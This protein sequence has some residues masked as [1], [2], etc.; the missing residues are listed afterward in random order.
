[1]F[2]Y[3]FFIRKEL[4]KLECAVTF[5]FCI[6]ST[7]RT[8]PRISGHCQGTWWLVSWDLMRPIGGELVTTT[9]LTAKPKSSPLKYSEKYSEIQC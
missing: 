7:G 5:S 6:S 3:T 4:Y 9:T 1:M 8:V 2:F